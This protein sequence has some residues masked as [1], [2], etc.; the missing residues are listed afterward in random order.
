MARNPAVQARA[1]AELDAVVGPTRLPE[2]ADRDALPYVTA[3][4][5]EV[6]RWR[7]VVPTGLCPLIPR[8]FHVGSPTR[9]QRSRTRRSPTRRCAGSTSPPARW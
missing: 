9:V 2:H 5:L 4:M 8:R 7:P 3:V 6:M 1:Q